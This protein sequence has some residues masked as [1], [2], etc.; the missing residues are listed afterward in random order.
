MGKRFATNLQ[1]DSI[2]CTMKISM[3]DF[4]TFNK[5]KNNYNYLYVYKNNYGIWNVFIAYKILENFDERG[6]NLSGRVNIYYM[7]F[8]IIVIKINRDNKIL[9]TSC[10]SNFRSMLY[11]SYDGEHSRNPTVRR[12][13]P[14]F[15]KRK[16]TCL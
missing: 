1:F 6:E 2:P 13:S 4:F 15:D 5:R 11:I 7:L 8:F 10:R 9:S 3:L 16:A 14:A 12:L